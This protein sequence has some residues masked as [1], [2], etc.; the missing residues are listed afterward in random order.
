MRACQPKNLE[1]FSFF[2]SDGAGCWSAPFESSVPE[3]FGLAVLCGPKG[4]NSDTYPFN[5]R[6]IAPVRRPLSTI[7]VT[8]GRFPALTC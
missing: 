4:G 5:R 2:L 6:T 3:R 1:F 8:F 7:A